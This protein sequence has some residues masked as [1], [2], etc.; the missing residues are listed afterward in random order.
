VS[1]NGTSARL[2]A[3]VSRTLPKGTVRAAEEHER[4]LLHD[5]EVTR[6]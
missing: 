5:V 6:A 2:R 1:S 3:R 4:G